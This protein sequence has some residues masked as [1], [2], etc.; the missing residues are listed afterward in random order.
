M[1]IK[2]VAIAF[3]L[4][5][6]CVTAFAQNKKELKDVVLND[7]IEETR[8][9]LRGSS[10]IHLVW[11]IPTE[12]WRAIYAQDE[13][14][15]KTAAQSIVDAMDAYTIVLV[16]D[17]EMVSLGTFTSKNEKTLRENLTVFDAAGKASKA[18]EEDEIDFEAQMMLDVLKPILKNLLGKLGDGIS[19]LAFEGENG[20][21]LDTY[22]KGGDVQYGETKLNYDLL[23]STLLEDK[24]CPK[25]QELMDA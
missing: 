3:V 11:W 10:G 12:S 14:I 20:K 2:N 16:V 15:V 5:L 23:L 7:L 21:I 22:K 6:L 4:I 1:K 8:V 9:N 17:E 24:K 18:L 25:D 13:S 19:I